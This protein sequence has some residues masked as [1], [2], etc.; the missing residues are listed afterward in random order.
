MISQDASYEIEVRFHFNDTDHAYEKLPFIR[1]CLERQTSWTTTF[2]GL[3]LFQSGQ[4]LR[5]SEVVL[6]E[7]SSYYIGWKGPDIG[8]F[9]NIRQEVDENI[10][11]AIADSSI[12]ESLGGNK[13]TG[14]IQ[15]VTRELERL[16]YH[17]FMSFKGID[18]AGYY[19]PYDIN[20][21][22]MTCKTLK[23]PFLVEMEKTANTEEEAIRCETELHELSHRLQLQSRLVR[24]EPPSLLYA[25]LFAH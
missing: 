20:I 8:K 1:S 13:N 19:E 23:W 22:L 24:E 4:L 21:K 14:G 9:A 16:G 17:R 15:G 25:R 3:E 10:T 6:N 18:L 2:Y 7:T 12:L 5:T 11:S